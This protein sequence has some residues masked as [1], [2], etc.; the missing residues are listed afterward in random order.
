MR[1]AI[2]GLIVA[3]SLI[4]LR[5]FTAAQN[6]PLAFEV[7]SIRPHQGPM[8]R[9]GA[10]IAG[11]RFTADVMTTYGLVMEAY[12]LKGYQVAFAPNLPVSDTQYD[13]AAKAGG[14]APPT[15]GSSGRCCKGF[16]M[17][18]SS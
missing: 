2:A 1:W 13:I 7:A 6:Q 5:I 12:D 4:M 16:S 9:V 11:Q 3:A 8:P 15:R 14:D 17:N 18:G 10:S